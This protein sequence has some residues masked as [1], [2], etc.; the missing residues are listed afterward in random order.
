MLPTVISGV[1]S[2]PHG[3]TEGAMV[4]IRAPWLCCLGFVGYLYGFPEGRVREVRDH[5]CDRQRWLPW[6]PSTTG[7]DKMRNRLSR[8]L[9]CE[10]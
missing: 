5:S 8:V 7:L 10:R 6:Q 1:E 2:V 9:C 4:G 3:W